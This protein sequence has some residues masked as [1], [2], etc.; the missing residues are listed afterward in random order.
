MLSHYFSKHS[1]FLQLPAPSCMTMG[2]VCFATHSPFCPPPWHTAKTFSPPK[3]RL[4]FRLHM[5]T[6]HGSSAA[7]T[8]LGAAQASLGTPHLTPPCTSRR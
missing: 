1:Q 2:E 3:P 6:T 8:S 5:A 4:I 7:G